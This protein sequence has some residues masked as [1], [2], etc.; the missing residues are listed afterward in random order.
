MPTS[1][2]THTQDIR[3]QI[4]PYTNA[5]K[6]RTVGPRVIER[7]EGIYV[8]DDQ[9][10]KY[11]EG[12]AGLWSVAAGFGEARLVEAA[13]RQM[14]KLP[15]YHTF[16]HKSNPPSIA[17]AERLIGYTQGRMSGVFFTNSG[18][19]AN[20]TVIKFV[21]YYNNA[22]GRPLKKKIIARQRGYHGVTVASASLTGL[23]GN[24]RDFDLPLPQMKHT[25]CPHYYRNANPGESEE[26]FATRMAAELEA[27]IQR[28][29]PE[30][31]AAFIGEPVMGAGGVIVPPH[32]YWP[33]VQAVCRKY[34]ILL[35]AD[36]V[37]TGFGRLGTFFGS[38]TY[39]IEPDIMVLSKQITSSYIPLAAV[40]VSPQ[41]QE[42]LAENSG[43]VGT[44]GHGYTASGHPVAT[45][46]ALENLNLIE[47][48]KLVENAAR[49]GEVL[50]RELRALAGH[51]LIGEVRG[52]GLIAGVELVADKASRTPFDPLGK[53]GAYAYEQAHTHGLIIR[54]IQDTVAFCPPLI[55]TPDEV[56]DMVARFSRTLD[57]VARFVAA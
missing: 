37:I 46:V 8:Y 53:A 38:D 26:A 48:R 56:R 10:N 28:E 35:I 29:G 52:V 39:G 5:V 18:S 9:G 17:L 40:L 47:E 21:W 45:A 49:S 14:S 13:S 19:E 4:H 57:D 16:T 15:Y 22:L 42:T 2:D 33:K 24:H 55:I 50:Q 36:E 11:L 51:P 7:G 6:H 54:G 25:A 44:L 27:L 31:I 43:R 34:D 32:T 41:V 30:T 23:A 12:M 1:N 20:D 3:H